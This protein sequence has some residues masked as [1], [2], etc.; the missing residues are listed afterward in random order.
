MAVKEIRSPVPGTFFRRPSPDT[1]PYKEVGD[2]VASGDVVGLVEVMKTFYPVTSDTAG[3]VRSFLVE[4]EGE[5]QA[6]QA[7]V[8]LE[9]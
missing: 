2:P 6:G 8:A 9:V 7:L 5:V 4:N 1:A 3:R